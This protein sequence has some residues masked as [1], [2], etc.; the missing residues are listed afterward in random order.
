VHQG[1]ER[2]EIRLPIGKGI[3]GY[4]AATGE[5]VNIPDAYADARFNP[6][7]DRASG[8]RTKTI[9]TMPMKNKEGAIIGVFQLLNKMGGE[10][11]HED[12]EYLDALSVPASLAVENAEVARQM[13]ENERLSAV[14]RMASS[15]IHDIKNPIGFLRIS[16]Q[17]IR[18]KSTKKEVQELADGMMHQIDRFVA[19]TQ[20][21]LDFSRGV[22]ALNKE[23]V[24]CEALLSTCGMFIEKDLREHKVALVQKHGFQGTIVVDREKLTR[25]FYNLAGNAADAMP[26]G[27]TLTIATGRKGNVLLVEFTDSG[28]GMSPKIRKKIFQPFFTH[29]KKHG[30]GLGLSIVKK[31]VDDHAGVIE[32]ESAEQKGTTVRMLLP[33][34]P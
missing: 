1:A 20:E 21:V 16:A 2:V 13:V 19:M 23:P 25:A 32:V 10:F 18:E 27:G 6:E 3:A 12:E 15:I 7:I 28:V 30:T 17:L 22:S 33:V 8:Y 34:I 29:G 26:E 5:T 14:G 11:S 31:I 24:D 4:V 9:L